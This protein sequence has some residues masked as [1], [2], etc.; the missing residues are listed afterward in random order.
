MRKTIVTILIGLGFVASL[1][2]QQLTA[3]EIHKAGSVIHLEVSFEPPK[4]EDL[5][6]I[7]LQLIAVDPHPQEESRGFVTQFNGGV[8][9]KRI[10]PTTF[11]TSIKIPNEA[12]TGDYKLIIMATVPGQTI[13]YESPA[14]FQPIIFHIRN[15]K[16]VPKPRITKVREIPHK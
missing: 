12:C 3:L 9:T 11:E 13:R 16:E 5:R 1:M 4:S 6:T 15:D 10:S 8:E 14:D 2:G 7:S